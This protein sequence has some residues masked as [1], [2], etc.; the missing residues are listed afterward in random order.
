M[1]KR[2][3]PYNDLPKL[4]PPTIDIGGIVKLLID[5]RVALA[6][7]KTA[8]RIIPDQTV[9]INSIVLQEAKLS[10][11]IENIVTTN[12]DLYKALADRQNEEVQPLLFPSPQTK[13]VLSYREALRC[14]VESI[15]S[16]PICTPLMEELATIT[17]GYKIGVRTIPGTKIANPVS[18]EIIYTPPEGEDVIR[19]LLSNL[20]EYLYGNSKDDPLIRMAVSHYQFE[21]IHPFNDGN[22]RTG[23][24]LNILY[25]VES[26]LLDIPTLYLSKYIIENKS[27]YYSGLRNVTEH[28]AWD[29]WIK[30][31]LTAVE[32]T[33]IGTKRK[34]E[35]INDLMQ[36]TAD[37]VRKEGGSIYSLDLIHSIFKQPY[38]KIKTVERDL[39]VGRQAASK[40]LNALKDLNILSE[41]RIGKEKYFINKNF[42][43]L[44]SR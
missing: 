35:S 19:E 27:A 1:L 8:G 39:N 16:K 28:G 10:S 44:L 17:K 37:H 15:K 24:I 20:E 36:S 2:D 32:Q 18:G 30:Y 41:I 33:A 5:A 14:G 38:S 31:M 43:S 25:L 42:M 13:E 3:I 4:P 40:Y 22:G 9:L 26:G 11:E 6:E 7:L 23:R 21:A 29:D 34:I 12:D